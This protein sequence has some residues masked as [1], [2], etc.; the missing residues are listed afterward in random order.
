MMGSQGCSTEVSLRAL[1]IWRRFDVGKAPIVTGCLHTWSGTEW[2]QQ[3]K[4]A[5]SLQAVPRLGAECGQ[6]HS[7]GASSDRGL[8]ALAVVIEL[9]ACKYPFDSCTA[10]FPLLRFQPCSTLAMCQTENVPRDLVGGFSFEKASVKYA[11]TMDRA[12]A[13]HKPYLTPIQVAE[14]LSD[15]AGLQPFP[16]MLP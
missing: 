11:F 4:K 14:Q 7:I 6:F 9:G 8:D 2:L 16:Q 5:T 12:W 3:N 1:G 10:A 13:T 15:A